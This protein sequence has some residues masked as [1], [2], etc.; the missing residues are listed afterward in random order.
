MTN[1][2]AITLLLLTVFAIGACTANTRDDQ[3]TARCGNLATWRLPPDP[4]VPAD[5]DSAAVAMNG[6][7][8][9]ARLNLL[10]RSLEH[11][12][13]TVGTYPGSL[14]QLFDHEYSFAVA[15]QCRADPDHRSDAWGNLFNYRLEDGVPRIVSAGADTEFGTVDDIAVARLADEGAAPIDLNECRE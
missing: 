8:T 4:I 14:N 13:A 15:S 12:C 5:L 3:A 1:R 2:C 10:A 11:Y 7:V 6:D 9:R